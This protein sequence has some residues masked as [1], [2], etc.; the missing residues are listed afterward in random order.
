LITLIIP[1]YVPMLQSLLGTVAL[2]ITDWAII[3]G[4]GITK[5]GLIELAKYYFIV[6]KEVDEV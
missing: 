2:S 5:L 1:I 6:N 3:F 4:F